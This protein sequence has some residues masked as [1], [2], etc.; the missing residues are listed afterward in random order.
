MSA[1]EI[2]SIQVGL[3]RTVVWKGREVTTGIFK[4]PVAGRVRVGRLNLEGDRQADLS[5]HGGPD[6]AVYAYP[7]EHYEWWRDELPGVPLPWGAFGENL[8]TRGLL[9]GDLAIGERL[10]IGTALFEVAQ[11]RMPCSKLAVKFEDDGIVARFLESGRSGFYLRVIHEGEIAAGQA[12]ERL[13][14]PGGDGMLTIADV[15]RLYAADRDN[16]DLL[17]RAAGHPALPESWR[18][19]AAARGQA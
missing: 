1:G 6:K 18:S 16:A 3:P 12:I 2:A 4:E 17:R 8:T 11:P 19:W 15:V 10:R 7:A 9:E 13:G 14:A 5:V